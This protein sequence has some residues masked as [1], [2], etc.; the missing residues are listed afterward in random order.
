MTEDKAEL[1]KVGDRVVVTHPDESP[2]HTGM[3]PIGAVG[4]IEHVY[5]N[6]YRINAEGR[7]LFYADHELEASDE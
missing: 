6:H 4:T 2:D 3:F 1:F 5:D 7:R